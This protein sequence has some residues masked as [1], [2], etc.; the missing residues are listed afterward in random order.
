MFFRIN[1]T[2]FKSI[3]YSDFPEARLLKNEMKEFCYSLYT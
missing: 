3:S 1:L 2:P